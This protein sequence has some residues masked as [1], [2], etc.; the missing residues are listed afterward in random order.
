MAGRPG[1]AD[2]LA[3]VRRWFEAFNRRD[4]AETLALAHPQIAFRPLQVHGATTWHGRA[5]VEALWER[6][7]SVGLDHRVEILRVEDLPGGGY[8]AIGR[9]KPGDADFVAVLRLQDGLVREARHVFSDED[10]LRGLGLTR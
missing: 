6:M 3:V 5:G 4:L 1:P 7:F 2:E 9:V 10:T 8:A